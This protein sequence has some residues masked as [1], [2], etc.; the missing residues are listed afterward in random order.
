MAKVKFINLIFDIPLQTMCQPSMG[1][2][3]KIITIF[4]E[5][6]DGLSYVERLPFPIT[7]A[8]LDHGHQQVLQL[9]IA[10]RFYE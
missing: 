4:C 2:D 5:K 1:Q 9:K 10:Y 7:I 6:T 8:L 3:N